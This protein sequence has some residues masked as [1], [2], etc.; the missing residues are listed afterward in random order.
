MNST[1][2]AMKMGVPMLAFP[3]SAD[4]P[5]VSKQIEDLGLGQR[6]DAETMTPAELQQTVQAMLEHLEQYKANIANIK[7]DQHSDKPGYVLAADRIFEF[8]NEFC[9]QV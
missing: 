3:Q 2:E 4:Q 8:R 5:V 6:L 7:D 1:N 9:P